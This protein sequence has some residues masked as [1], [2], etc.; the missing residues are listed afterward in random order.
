MVLPCQLRPRGRGP[1][2]SPIP[3]RSLPP[4]MSNF[5]SAFPSASL[6]YPRRLTRPLRWIVALGFILIVPWMTQRCLAEQATGY[7][8]EDVNGNE[9]LDAGEPRLC[10][11]RVSNGVDIVRTD[12]TGRYALEVDD[13]TILFVIK[14]RG[15]RTPIDQQQLKVLLP[16]QTSRIAPAAILQASRRPVNCRPRSTFRFTV[17]RSRSISKQFCLAIH[18]RAISRRSS[19]SAT[20]WCRS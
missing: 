3:Y 8:F 7:V 10:G 13:D 6:P 5:S 17:K 4:A 20:T 14:P 1:R 11:I 16:P 19:T 2:L 12:Q 9:Q 15:Y 18:S